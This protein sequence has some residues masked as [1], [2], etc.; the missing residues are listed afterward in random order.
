MRYSDFAIE[1]NKKWLFETAMKN[2]TPKRLA[3]HLHEAAEQIAQLQ[4]ACKP[5]L[6]EG[7]IGMTYKEFTDVEIVKAVECCSEPCCV[8]D[9]CPL[10][11]VGAN[12][13]SFELH[14]Y[15]LDLINR[16]KSEI[17]RLKSANDEKFRQ[18]DMLAEKSKQHYADLYNE[19]KDILKAEAYKEFAE[20]MKK[21][22]FYKC[23][24]INYSETCDLRKLIDN[25]LK[26]MV[27]EEE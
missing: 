25:L 4:A 27:G 16:Q 20:R 17:E 18:W 26:E 15:A 14:R 22:L 5:P 10:Y 7:E 6:Q 3:G 21:D 23:G 12:C 13:S 1:Q 19:A 24:D 2:S 11:C 9:E 8:C